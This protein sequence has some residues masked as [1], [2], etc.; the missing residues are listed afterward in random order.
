M[1]AAYSRTTVPVYSSM[2]KFRIPATPYIHDQVVL[3]LDHSNMLEEL[4]GRDS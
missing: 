1:W 2:H 3:N 4:H